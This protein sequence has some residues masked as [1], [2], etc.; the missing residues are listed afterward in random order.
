M[1]NPHEVPLATGVPVSV[2]TATPVEQL[3]VP[4]WH[5]LVGVHAAFCVHDLHAPLSQT[6]LV[7]HDV[8]LAA[9]VP[10][11][12]HTGAPVVQEVVPAWH[13]LVGVHGPFCV[14]AMH[15]P[16]SQTSLVPHEVAL[17]RLVPVSV[18]T[19]VPVVQDVVPA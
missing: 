2:H 19:G 12:L 6:S 8:P 15:A 1:R 11:S 18:H 10:V 3:M 4:V 14:H 7:P 17:A 9:V 5:G 16:L 13:G